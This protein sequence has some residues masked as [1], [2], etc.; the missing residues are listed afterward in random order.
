MSK[1]IP[2]DAVAQD[3]EPPLRPPSIM[4]HI[5]LLTDLSKSA[6]HAAEFAIKLFGVM[7]NTYVLCHVYE[8]LH[9][10]P[11]KARL[12]T[13]ASARARL[14]DL[15]DHLMQRFLI[16]PPRQEMVHG[17]LG[18]VLHQLVKDHDAEVIVVGMRG[19]GHHTGW[20]RHAIY[21]AKHSPM[22]VLVVPENAPTVP[23]QRI[24]FAD[25]GQEIRA[26]SLHVLKHIAT[27]ASAH[28]IVGHV[29]ER[30]LEPATATNA[31]EMDRLLP[32]VPL[33]FHL[34]RGT[35]VIDGIARIV[36]HEHI[37]ML[38]VLHR[39]IGIVGRAFHPSTT[40]D[41]VFENELPLL[42]LQQDDRSA[43]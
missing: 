10:S 22:P 5:L 24:L 4:A 40:K 42:V 7:G 19:M 37:G 23:V 36:R 28:V 11:R 34:V 13:P 31:P 25:D 9:A 30:L 32:G 35:D 38:A 33:T 1:I 17:H 18:D 12:R 29:E 6:K 27:C 8:S 16:D 21:V 14:A 41:L 15:G 3:E 26:K 2:P 39:N 20:G 43:T